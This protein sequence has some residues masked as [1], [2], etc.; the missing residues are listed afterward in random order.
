MRSKIRPGQPVLYFPNTETV[1][2]GEA[3]YVE[4][5]VVILAWGR[6][7]ERVRKEVPRAHVVPLDRAPIA[8]VAGEFRR[9]SKA[10]GEPIGHTIAICPDCDREFDLD[11][12]PE[13]L[14]VES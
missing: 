1:W 5:S 8:L 6:G 4:E 14:E 13:D 7:E 11:I 10:P 3:E 12:Y 9:V 2:V